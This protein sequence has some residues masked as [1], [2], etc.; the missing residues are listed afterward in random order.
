[1]ECI[2]AYLLR[3]N[4]RSIAVHALQLADFS[5][6]FLWPPNRKRQSRQ[7]GSCD[8]IGPVSLWACDLILALLLSYVSVYLLEIALAV[9]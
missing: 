8:L 6:S 7:S 1:M 2:V 5:N 9:L 3:D 4:E